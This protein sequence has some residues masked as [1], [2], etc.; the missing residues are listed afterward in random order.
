MLRI[1][2][3][4]ACEQLAR[5][6]TTPM[7][8]DASGELEQKENPECPDCGRPTIWV[9]GRFGVFFRCEDQQCP[10]KL[11]PKGKGGK[12]TT[13]K[14]QGGGQ[15]RKRQKAA[16]GGTDRPCPEP[17]CEGR[18]VERKGRYGRFL[19]CSNYPRC[20]HTESIS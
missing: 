20:R 9:N 7:G 4:A 3:E 1:D 14:R 17:G 6:V 8:K 10:G 11:N 12:K 15:R 19:G 2:S 13:G 18:M 16:P 5:F